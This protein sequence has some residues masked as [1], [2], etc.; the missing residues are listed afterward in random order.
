MGHS[1]NP[2]GATSCGLSWWILKWEG[3]TCASGW[4]SQSPLS[5]V[6][7]DGRNIERR[8]GGP[9]QLRSSRWRPLAASFWRVGAVPGDCC[10]KIR[11]RCRGTPEPLVHGVAHGLWER[12]YNR[13]AWVK[14]GFLPTPTPDN[15]HSSRCSLF[16][17]AMRTI[18]PFAPHPLHVPMAPAAAT[19]SQ[20]HLQAP[21][22]PSQ[23][24]RSASPQ[25]STLAL[26]ISSPHAPLH[27]HQSGPSHSPHAS[28]PTSPAGA[29]Q[30]AVSTIQ[31]IL[32]SSTEAPGP[33]NGQQHTWNATTSPIERDRANALPP[34][35]THRPNKR[36]LDASEAEDPH[37]KI[38][39]VVRDHVSQDPARVMPMT[40]VLCLHAAVAQKSYGSEKRFLCPPPVV[41]IE[42][43][44]WNM[45]H[46]QLTMAVV[47]EAG[48]RS[49]EQKAPLDHSLT[50]SFKFLHVNG[51]AKTK[52]FQLSLD[53]AEPQLTAD[54]G[55]ASSTG[56][57]WASFDSAPVTII[58]KPS[59]KTAKTRNISSCIL[60]GGP[61]SL[62]N[63]INSQTV[64]TKY[65]TVERSQ[66]CASN[67]AWSAFNVNV[68][69]PGG[70]GAHN[71]GGP[72]PVTYGSEIV[73]ADTVS[74]T[75]TAPLVI[76][77]VDK[78]RIASDD[79][80]PVSQMQKIALQRV[81]SDGSRHY[82]S[83]AGPM[84]G[85]PGVVVPS[86][87]GLSNQAGTHPLLFQAPRVREEV[88]DGTRVITDEVDDYLCWT[89]VGI[90][91]FQYTFFDAFGQNNNIP[92]MP[93][94]PFPTL[95]TAPVYRP[96]SHTLE[97]TA[98]N[99]FYEDPKTRAQVPLDIYLGNIGP[100]RHRVY[101]ATPPGPMTNIAT[102]VNGSSGPTH[103]PAGEL[104]ASSG[105]HYSPDM[106][107]HPQRYSHA[108]HLHTIVHVD[109]PPVADVLKA[110]QDDAVAS[111]DVE[112]SSP[113]NGNGE[114]T[115]SGSQRIKPETIAGRSLP[116]LFI[117]AFDGV[118]YHS[119]R[120]IACENVFHN[121]DLGNVGNAATTPPAV[122]GG[123][124]A[125]AQ[126]AANQV[127][128]GLYGWTLRVI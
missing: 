62:F 58:S 11:P 20:T 70:D 36:K 17:P 45:K 125:A 114:S 109:L 50:A 89:I 83:A 18:M 67:V 14:D 44:V 65:M 19:E 103:G 71:L 112:S 1:D 27:P 82:L 79:G 122:N 69:R 92:D 24:S 86:A 104:I 38:R 55:D 97:L 64:R 28:H 95:F 74:G 88:K 66:L 48:E 40:T 94:T 35:H 96:P 47:S 59:K 12:L 105:P 101:Q 115:P 85:A 102:F 4:T 33:V 29:D 113:R 110:L 32:A 46:Q 34:P 10:G 119:G 90:S 52:S 3:G 77:K 43:P 117:R 120:A 108:G 107:H 121:I 21:P 80:G 6:C 81:N 25:Q 57:V 116:L 49:C 99:F 31:S 127:D 87:P 22:N 111:G 7:I 26:H 91:K 51:S 5:W 68:V 23:L 54:A 84:P 73:L 53:I 72:Q 128:D 42:G 37:N 8:V 16:R 100:L 61:V 126:E 15:S 106:G 56:R 98:S 75:Q 123:L 63:R 60:A 41:H 76:R 30:Q 118:G 2:G 93:I 39:R 78:G 13:R 124:M 9:E